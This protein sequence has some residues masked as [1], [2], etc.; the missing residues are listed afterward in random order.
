MNPLMP[1]D[2]PYIL[3]ISGMVDGQ[4]EPPHA[5]TEPQGSQRP[6][7][8][9]QYE[10]CGVYQR[11]YRNRDATAYESACPRCGRPVRVRVGAGG[12]SNRMFKAR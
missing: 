6:W 2:P 3:D 5:D 4:P 8:G 9:I 11:V 12:T 10:C 7:I 1:D